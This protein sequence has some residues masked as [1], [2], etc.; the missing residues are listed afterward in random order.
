MS[1][2]RIAALFSVLALATAV[3]LAAAQQVEL[4]L[5]TG[6]VVKGELIIED[7]DK[8]VVKSTTVGKS[9][10]DGS[11][12]ELVTAIPR[13]VPALTCCI[14]ATAVGNATSTVPDITSTIDGLSPL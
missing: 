14:T 11:R 2:A 3:P 7:N 5:R 4:R 8:V 9:G 12:L 10:S 13:S 1:I 6:A